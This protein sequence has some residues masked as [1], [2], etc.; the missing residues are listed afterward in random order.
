VGSKKHQGRIAGAYEGFLQLP[1]W[2]VLAGLWLAGVALI[3]LFISLFGLAF[4]VL[5]Y[6]LIYLLGI[7]S[8]A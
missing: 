4:Y 5:I 2:V 1:V 8:G 3:S 6:V 7:V